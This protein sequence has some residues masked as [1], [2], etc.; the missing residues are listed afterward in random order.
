VATE[1]TY[2]TTKHRTVAK[3]N[4][5]AI[6]KHRE[7]PR[8]KSPRDCMRTAEEAGRFAA[9]GLLAEMPRYLVLRDRRNPGDTYT[10]GDAAD[11]EPEECEHPTHDS[12]LTPFCAWQLQIPGYPTYS[13]KCNH[14]V[15]DRTVAR[16]L[17]RLSHSVGK[18]I[19]TFRIGTLGRWD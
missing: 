3:M 17:I 16:R 10:Y 2:T 7:S 12:F 4:T 13:P 15:T 1:R 18:S 11:R 9:A 8:E 14:S 19:L 5:S 6:G